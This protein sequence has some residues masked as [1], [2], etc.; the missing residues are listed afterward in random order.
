[1]KFT[2][3]TWI[4]VISICAVV[5][6]GCVFA[7]ISSNVSKNDVN[8]A[9]KEFAENVLGGTLPDIDVKWEL[10]QAM[11]Q[12]ETAT[13]TTAT[14]TVTTSTETV[15]TTSAVSTNVDGNSSNPSSPSN[16][17]GSSS[18]SKQIRNIQERVEYTGGD[19]EKGVLYEATVVAVKTANC[20]ALDVKG[21]RKTADF[22]YLL[23]CMPEYTSVDNILEYVPE[24]EIENIEE[25]RQNV[26]NN[27]NVK[28]E[29]KNKIKIY[30]IVYNKLKQ[31][32][33]VYIEFDENMMPD[34]P[35]DNDYFVYL[36]YFENEED[37]A[38]GT[39]SLFQEWLL[40]KGYTDVFDDTENQ[41]YLEYFEQLADNA[42]K[43]F[44]GLWNGYFKRE[45]DEEKMKKIAMS[46]S[47]EPVA[48]DVPETEN[49][50]NQTVTAEVTP[51]PQE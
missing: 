4:A 43:N 24:D 41:K 42:D 38:N 40:N 47:I 11:K 44:A 17:S 37:K 31:G 25:I 21:G 45:T 1:M 3:K 19:L 39:L 16:P 29:N 26:L 10:Q 2:K 27:E 49:T 28:E 13:E 20:I 15:T 9:S 30:D 35:S 34:L 23:V 48:T 6:G 18:S 12:L 7:S 14:T 33:T 5:C 50:E 51:V 46:T 32:D 8:K 36:W 22:K